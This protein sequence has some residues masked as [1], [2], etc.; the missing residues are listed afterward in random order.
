MWNPSSTCDLVSTPIHG[1]DD[2][3]PILDVRDRGVIRKVVDELLQDLLRGGMRHVVSMP[4]RAVRTGVDFGASKTEQGVVREVRLPDGC[5]DL[6]L[7]MNRPR[8]SD[9]M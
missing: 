6:I 5:V 1:I 7:A 2:V 8:L 4:W 9:V 3:Q